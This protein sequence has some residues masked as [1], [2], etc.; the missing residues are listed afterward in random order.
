MNRHTASRRC[1]APVFGI[2]LAILAAFMRPAESQQVKFDADNWFAE[3]GAL[4]DS[5]C[6]IIGVFRN[7]NAAGPTGSFSLLVDLRNR[8]TAIV[9]KPSPSKATVRVDKYQAFECQGREYCIFS[10]SDSEAIARQLKSGS[11]V[12]IDV[13]AGGSILR[14]SISTKGYQTDLGKIRAQGFRNVLE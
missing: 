13:V 4:P 12:L 10:T 5:D 7:N 3:C 6:S 14:A 11:L 1:H 2:C 9:G 8:M